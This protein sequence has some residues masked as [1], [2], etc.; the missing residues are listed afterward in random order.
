MKPFD[1]DAAK[2]GAPIQTR[3][4]RPAKLV[5]HVP[6]ANPEYRVLALV[7]GRVLT[8]TT[9]GTFHEGTVASEKDLFMTPAK[10]GGWLNIYP[11]PEETGVRSGF[12]YDSRERADRA[13]HGSRREACIFIE[14]EEYP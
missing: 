7:G 8:Y 11:D 3:D 10:R 13:A 14:W 12:I 6:E 9:A 5:A 2:N 4:G 1:L